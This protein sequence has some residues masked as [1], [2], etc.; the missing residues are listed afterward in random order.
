MPSRLGALMKTTSGQNWALCRCFTAC[1]IE[2]EKEKGRERK[3]VKEKE[4][5]EKSQKQNVFENIVN[6]PRI[7]VVQWKFSVSL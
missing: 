5:K 1:N 4:R 6:K 3:R 2:G 7:N